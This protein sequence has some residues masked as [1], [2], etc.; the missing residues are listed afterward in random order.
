MNLNFSIKYAIAFCCIAL[1]SSNAWAQN[2]SGELIFN[3]DFNRMNTGVPYTATYTD[4]VFS[5]YPWNVKQGSIGDT[6]VETDIEITMPIW[7]DPRIVNRADLP[8][9]DS[10]PV[11]GSFMGFNATVGLFQN[12]R[13]FD[14][15][16]D[17]TSLPDSITIEFYY[18]EYNRNTD[19]TDTS[20]GFPSPTVDLEIRLDDFNFSYILRADIPNLASTNGTPGTWEKRSLT[21]STADALIT[22]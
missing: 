15:S 22:D 9:F 17:D 20:P 3:G 12:V 16:T 10:S 8:G 18:T 11:G 21:F 14:T 5:P 7:L 19:T 13:F 1:M 6:E 2:A 4:A